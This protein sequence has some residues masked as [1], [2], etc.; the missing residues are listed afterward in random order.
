M[1]A[2]EKGRVKQE[3]LTEHTIGATTF[4]VSRSFN[5]TARENAETKMKRIL[6][7]EAAQLVRKEKQ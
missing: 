6:Q 4:I 7:S 2:G 1:Q 5:P 3:K